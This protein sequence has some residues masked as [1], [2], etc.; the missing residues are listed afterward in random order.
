MMQRKAK[1]LSNLPRKPPRNPP[2]PLGLNTPP[3]PL[4]ANIVLN[5]VIGGWY[6]YKIFLPLLNDGTLVR[7]LMTL[8]TGQRVHARAK[9]SKR[10]LKSISTSSCCS[11]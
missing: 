3:L 10:K 7:F 4:P 8:T 5:T 1:P 9:Q 6:T 11:L 2:R